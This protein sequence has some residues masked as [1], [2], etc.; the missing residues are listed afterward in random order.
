MES[1]CINDQT[2]TLNI[3]G[4]IKST[5]W[6]FE[7]YLKYAYLCQHL[8]ADVIIDRIEAI[9]PHYWLYWA[10][11]TAG[12][13]QWTR[14]TD[15]ISEVISHFASVQINSDSEALEGSCQSMVYRSV[16]LWKKNT[17]GNTFKYGH[18]SIF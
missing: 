9:N 17:Y 6:E 18:T 8:I 2:H 11:F 15:K 3:I 14:S 12:A 7:N 13:L 16:I 10:Y 5:G 4:V 1:Q